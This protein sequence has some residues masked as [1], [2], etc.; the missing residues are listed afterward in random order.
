MR[1]VAGLF[2]KLG[3]LGFG[4]PA[5]HI[6][7]MRDEVVRRR[8]W[9]DDREFLHL[10]ALSNLTPGPT[11]TELAL[12]LGRSR[13]GLPGMLVAGA[14]FIVPAAAL[15]LGLAWLYVAAGS[16]PRV[17]GLLAGVRAVMV[18]VLVDAIARLA[19]AGLGSRLQLAAGALAF[20]LALAGMNEL[21]VMLVVVVVALVVSLRPQLMALL[22]ARGPF[23]A[24]E[25]VTLFAIFAAFLKIGALLY[26]T[27]YVL[28][29]YLRSEL[30]DR[31]WLSDAQILDA[32]AVGQMT[33]GPVL[34]S[35]TFAGYLL[36]GVPGAVIATVAIFL[37]AFI[38]V[39]VAGAIAARASASPRL[40]LASDVLVAAALG[41]LLAAAV[42]LGDDVL[43]TWLSTLVFIA[44]LAVLRLTRL[45]A[46]WLLAAGA[47]VGLLLPQLL[48]G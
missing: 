39:A 3:V 5:A 24:L 2:L 28:V 4:G 40:R 13:R 23:M 32:V 35:A 8:R 9:L 6:A 20:A 41:L 29:A 43:R 19:P 33:P 22:T 36:A 25:P 44:A 42:G 27:G 11:S 12:H 10:V 7:L 18:A 16:L 38:F 14:L 34:S 21:A 47:I 45:G 48:V 31:G 17:D 30:V 1:E 15:S 26:G 46:G 37:P